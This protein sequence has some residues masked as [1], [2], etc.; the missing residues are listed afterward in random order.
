[1]NLGYDTVNGK[2]KIKEKNTARKDRYSSIAYADY[3][4]ETII[5]EKKQSEKKVDEFIFFC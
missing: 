4:C 1:M 2:I 3:L 5:E